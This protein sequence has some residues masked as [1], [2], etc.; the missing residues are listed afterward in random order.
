MD[1]IDSQTDSSRSIK[2]QIDTAEPPS[3]SG[4]DVKL[5]FDLC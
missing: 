4:V 2:M 5:I 1:D 3:I